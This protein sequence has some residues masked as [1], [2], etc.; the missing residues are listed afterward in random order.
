V[1]PLVSMMLIPP[2]PLSSGGAAWNALFAPKGTPKSILDKLTDALDKALD[3]ATT[4]KRLLELG[5]DIP[6]KAGGDERQKK[7][8]CDAIFHR[9]RPRLSGSCW[10]KRR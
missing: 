5:S 7:A 1:F 9:R 10:K 3:D 4:R 6:D 8:G 2:P